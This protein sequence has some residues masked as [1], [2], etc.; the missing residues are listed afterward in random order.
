MSP[1]RSLVVLALLIAPLCLPSTAA[2]TCTMTGNKELVN[3]TVSPAVVTIDPNAAVGTV[4]AT[5]PAAT[6]SPATSEID[7]TGTTSIGVTNLVGTQP[8]GSSTIFPTGVAGVG[9]R[10]LHPSSSYYL[11]PWGHDTIAS[12]TYALSVQSGI[13]LVKT[14]PIAPGATLNAATLGYWEYTGRNS[15][16]R[17][18][19]FVL[20][21]SVKFVAPTCTVTTTNIAVTLP[22]VSDNSLSATGATA[23]ATAFNI[24]LTCTAAASGQTMAIQF[25]TNRPSSG[26]T[27]V[28]TLNAGST[29]NHVGVQL[30]DSNFAAVTFGT[31]DTVGT[32]PTG[33]YN[34]TYYARYYA[35]TNG[36]TA[37]SVRAT[38]TFTISY[39]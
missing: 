36:V 14:G 4:L 21:N 39:P 2:A 24:G 27:G 10:I 6:P 18:E 29:A 32:T 31:P 23:G 25:D 19:D 7:C 11:L 20:L 9:Y 35:L 8:A 26:I 12:G 28:L 5:A 38:A 16:L 1:I 17:V 37:G 15:T 3:M 33:A 13:Q 34:L 30:V 22:T